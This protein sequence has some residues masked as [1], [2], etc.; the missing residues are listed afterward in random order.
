MPTSEQPTPV[1]SPHGD[2]ETAPVRPSLKQ[3]LTDPVLFFAFGF[4][5]GLAPKGPGTAGTLVAVLLYPLLA[6]LPMYAYLGFL[7]LAVGVGILV[8]GAAADKLGVHDHG[9]IVWDEFAG[10][11]LAMIGAPATWPWLLGGF[12]L[13]RIFDIWKPWPISLLDE[14]VGGGFGIMLDDLLAGLYTLV[15]LSLVRYLI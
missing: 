2:G 3:V 7:V 4:G 14:K 15:L 8:C 1:G 5:S 13:F 10:F 11:W 9:G 12:V 6:I